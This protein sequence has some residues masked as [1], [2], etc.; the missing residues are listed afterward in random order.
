MTNP[1]QFTKPFKACDADLDLIT[2]PIMVFPKIDGVRGLNREGIF[3]GRS[4]KAHKSLYLQDVLSGMKYSGLDGELSCGAVTS[5]SLCRD[6]TSATGTIKGSFDFDYNCFDLLDAA[7]MDM[8]YYDRYAALIERVATLPIFVKVIPFSW[9]NNKEEVLALYDGYIAEGYEGAVL[10]DP[11]AMHKNGRS[12][13]KQAGYLRLKPCGDAEGIFHHFDEAMHNGNE[14]KKN[15][16]GETE[17]SSHKENKTGLGMIG[18]LWLTPIGGGEPFKVGPGT[19]N[20]HDRGYYF[21]HPTV[22]EGRIIKFKFFDH[23]AKDAYRHARF[24]AFRN[25][26]DMEC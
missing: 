16:L 13:K 7:Y 4:L 12:T 6:T 19:M 25:A 22:L 3:L 15:A 11:E 23:G 21:E 17:R 2:Y 14:A 26:S 24:F 18:A 8:P 5:Q 10:R 20:H 9:A 1:I